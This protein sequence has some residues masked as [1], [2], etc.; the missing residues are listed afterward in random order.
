MSN[1]NY[2]IEPLRE[3][4]VAGAKTINPLVRFVLG[5]QA[6]SDY[7]SINPNGRGSINIEL[8][9]GSL[10]KWILS[11]VNSES[12]KFD[13]KCTIGGN[14]GRSLSVAGGKVYFPDDVASISSMSHTL[15]SSDSGKMIY[16]RLT[17]KTLG[18]LVL[19]NAVT[20]T[21]MT[22]NDDY[23]VCLPIATITY[24]SGQYGIRYQHIGSFAFESLPYFWKD[25]YSKSDYQF[26]VHRDGENEERWESAND[27]DEENA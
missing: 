25:G 22:G 15:S 26:L 16:V 5:I 6:P 24:S 20:H 7:L 1:L 19:D 17:S 11:M 8:D 14:N 21:L 3:N 9:S 10:A 12:L 23:R 13:F 2:D 18:T 27:C 4:E